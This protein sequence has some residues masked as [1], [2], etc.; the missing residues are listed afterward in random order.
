[1]KIISVS[2]YI[3][4]MSIPCVELCCII[5]GAG[6]GGRRG[7]RKEEEE[8]KMG[9]EEGHTERDR[10]RDRDRERHRETDRERQTETERD[11]ERETETEREREDKTR[12][13]C[14]SDLRPITTGMNTEAVRIVMDPVTDLNSV[15]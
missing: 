1:M 14:L 7:G 15:F 6:E 9:G 8:V 3:Y 4:L 10:E 13:I 11:R 12:L 5:R 2:V